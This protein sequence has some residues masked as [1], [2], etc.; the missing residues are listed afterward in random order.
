[1]STLCV[2]CGNETLREDPFFT[3]ENNCRYGP[4]RESDFTDIVVDFSDL[5]SYCI[6]EKCS[7]NVKY[8]KALDVMRAKNSIEDVAE[9]LTRPRCDNLFSVEINYRKYYLTGEISDD[10]FYR[11]FLII[12]KF[13]VKNLKKMI[14]KFY[15]E[16]FDNFFDYTLK[17]F[18][19][20]LFIRKM[21]NSGRV[22]LT[23]LS[24]ITKVNTA[25]V[26]FLCKY[27]NYDYNDIENLGKTIEF[28]N[29]Y[30]YLSITELKRSA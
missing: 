3:S 14:D 15:S 28:I 13:A 5:N 29:R 17:A 6:C 22:T 2:I 8:Y 18:D 9:I 24:L 12:H 7:P 23:Y 27:F 26:S 1:M 21:K 30:K 11:R 16:I 20:E 10:E 25:K 4:I 19:N